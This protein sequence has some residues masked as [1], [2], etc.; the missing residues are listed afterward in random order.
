M[1]PETKENVKRWLI[2]AATSFLSGF[3]LF[4][5]ADGMIDSITLESFKDG[6]FVGLM[7]LAVRSGFKALIEGA[8][9]LIATYRR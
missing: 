9:V 2:S 1:S 8:A 5:A 4:L 3:V 6:S 7:F